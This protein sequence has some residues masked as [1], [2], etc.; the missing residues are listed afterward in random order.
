MLPL[1]IVIFYFEKGS[2]YCYRERELRKFIGHEEETVSNS[3]KPSGY[4]NQRV[5]LWTSITRAG[6]PDFL[7]QAASSLMKPLGKKCVISCC[8]A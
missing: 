3:A 4:I 8:L 1:I 5:S 6:S 2:I 7:Q